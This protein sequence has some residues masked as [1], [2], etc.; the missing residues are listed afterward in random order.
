VAARIS[1]SGVAPDFSAAESRR[2]SSGSTFKKSIHG[3][4]MSAI[5]GFR[6]KKSLVK[7]F[8]MN[9]AAILDN[10]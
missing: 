5:R 9:E 10:P 6:R 4:S 8:M 3:L 7:N 1:E 2:K